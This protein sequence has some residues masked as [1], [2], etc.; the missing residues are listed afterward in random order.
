MSSQKKLYTWWVR[1]RVWDSQGTLSSKLSLALE[2]EPN[3]NE[4]TPSQSDSNSSN[5]TEESSK[6]QSILLGVWGVF[7]SGE[8]GV[9]LGMTLR[10]FNEARSLDFLAVDDSWAAFWGLCSASRVSRMD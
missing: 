1:H 2:S 7:T 3:K 5:H 8:G 6:F 10:G 9:L 4:R